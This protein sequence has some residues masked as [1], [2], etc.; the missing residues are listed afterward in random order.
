MK[1]LER[2]AKNNVIR[3]KYV[4][5]HIAITNEKDP[6]VRPCCQYLFG[7]EDLPNALEANTIEDIING[8]H[9]QKL[10]KKLTKNVKVTSCNSCWQQEENNIISKR[11]S[12]A[13]NVKL[14][15]VGK[16]Q[17]IEIGLDYTCNMTCRMC[18]SFTSSSFN[19]LTTM[20]KK[21]DKLFPDDELYV[22]YQRQNYTKHILELFERSDLSNLIWV[23]LT[24]GEPFYSK[25][26]YRFIELLI[27]KAPYNELELEIITNGSIFP[28]EKLLSMLK[29]FKSVKILL[30][31]DAVG[32][33]AQVCRPPTKWI[34]ILDNF[35]KYKESG[36]EI[37]VTS[38]ITIMN[39]NKMHELVNWWRRRTP[40]KWRWNL[41]TSPCRYPQWLSPYNLSKEERLKWHTIDPNINLHIHSD[42]TVDRPPSWSQI[43]K[44]IDT[45]DEQF[46]KKFRNV[47][48]EMYR[49]IKDKVKNNS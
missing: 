48:K 25:S 23:K 24:G 8:E 7:D 30:S 35:K 44:A 27:Q 15:A 40:P 37:Y 4:E 36:L 43:L 39:V 2:R 33:L 38:T 47:N 19:K 29:Q 46:E 12:I 41:M 5:S 9:R 6:V 34:T 32:D 14:D 20:N 26:I 3:C 22:P 11:T 28:S 17:H 31:I 16:L 1:A 49:I 13:D 10:L 21:L 42:E 18:N 45:T